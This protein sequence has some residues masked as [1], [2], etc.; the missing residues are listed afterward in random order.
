M[1]IKFMSLRLSARLRLRSL[2]MS[3]LL[4]GMGRSAPQD[5]MRLSGGGGG[6]NHAVA[7][8]HSLQ[9]AAGQDEAAGLGGGDRAG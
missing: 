9:S 7:G 5:R 1:L 4:A 2:K 3:P 6:F 8:R